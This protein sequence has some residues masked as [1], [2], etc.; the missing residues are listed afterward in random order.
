METFL[1]WKKKKRLLAIRRCINNIHRWFR[2]ISLDSLSLDAPGLLWNL[3]EGLPCWSSDWDSALPLQ[4]TRVQS[5]VREPRSLTPHGKAKTNKPLQTLW[6]PFAFHVFFSILLHPFPSPSLLL[7]KSNSLPP[8]ALIHPHPSPYLFRCVPK[9]ISHTRWSRRKGLRGQRSLSNVNYQVN[10]L[11]VHW[12]LRAP[13]NALSEDVFPTCLGSQH[14]KPV[15]AL[16]CAFPPHLF[17]KC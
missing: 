15:G 1:N 5:L 10:L 2:G 17:T 7:S 9:N 4:G 14:P 11:E 12:P 3:Q 13:E 6:M 8:P 16:L